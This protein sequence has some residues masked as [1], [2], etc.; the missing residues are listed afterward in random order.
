MCK[1]MPTVVLGA[2]GGVPCWHHCISWSFVLNRTAKVALKGLI[3]DPSTHTSRPAL[4]SHLTASARQAVNYDFGTSMAYLSRM[5][6]HFSH[7]Q[8]TQ[9]ELRGA[10]TRRSLNPKP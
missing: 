4:C 3:P 8:K 6:V 7:V 5:S 2:T 1:T 9:K 10:C